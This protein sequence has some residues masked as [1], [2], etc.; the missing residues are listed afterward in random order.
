MI[1]I[2]DF[3]NKKMQNK[4]PH[5]CCSTTGLLSQ[6]GSAAAHRHTPKH[7]LR[8]MA[9][10]PHESL[11]CSQGM[12][13]PQHPIWTPDFI[14]TEI[15]PTE[16]LLKSQ[17]YAQRRIKTPME[18]PFTLPNTDSQIRSTLYY[19][20]PLSKPPSAVSCTITHECGV[21]YLLKL[22]LICG[23]GSLSQG[24]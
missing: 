23:H 9:R 22:L 16:I 21:Q 18:P 15:Q 24:A 5:G 7:I 3:R 19:Q 4:P 20:T 13:S 14:L 11:H 10:R 1:G 6:Q 12:P 2:S 8:N 17:C